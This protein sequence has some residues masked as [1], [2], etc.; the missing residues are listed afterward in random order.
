MCARVCGACV[1]ETYVLCSQWQMCVRVQ[2]EVQR[3]LQDELLGDA[4]VQQVVRQRGQRE[5]RGHL[6]EGGREECGSGG[7]SGP[8]PLGGGAS[9]EGRGL[10]CT[11]SGAAARLRS[12][13]KVSSW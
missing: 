2:Q 1:C 6:E 10:T 7:G 5:V 4:P 8:E 12:S 11:T 3:V 9:G 13:V